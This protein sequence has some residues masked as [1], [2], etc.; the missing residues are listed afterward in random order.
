M[1][2]EARRVRARL[3]RTEV[4]STSVEEAAALAKKKAELILLA[5]KVKSL[6]NRRDLLRKGGVTLSVAPDTE[7]VKQLCSLMLTRFSESPK[8]TTLVDK[9]RW[10]KLTE[11]LIE[12]NASEDTL[13]KQDWKGYYGTKLFGGVSPEQ[14]KQT[15]L[16]TLPE[17]Q[18][19]WDRYKRLYARFA[20]FRNS[21][22]NSAE[23]LKD[24]QNC[25]KELTDIRFIE[26][27]D[28]P[29]AVRAFFNATSTGNGANLDLLTTE[30]IDW[31]R[32]N[33]MLNNFAVRAR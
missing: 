25:S 31:L 1:L 27:D 17:N 28:V 6:A 14:R 8:A 13:Q 30:V 3:V 23:D 2:N 20:E 10:T 32:T 5:A 33:N 4:A 22:P 29:M 15:I 9:Q 21:L 19:E 16:M 26:N 11:A 7:K 24:V 18:K 12:F